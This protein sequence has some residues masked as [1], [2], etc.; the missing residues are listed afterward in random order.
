LVQNR[1]E[2]S[3]P[4]SLEY[5]AIELVQVIWME[6]A[7]ELLTFSWM[8]LGLQCALF[9]FQREQADRSLLFWKSLPVPD[10]IAVCAK[11]VFVLGVLPACAALSMVLVHPLSLSLASLMWPQASADIWQHLGSRFFD[12][13]LLFPLLYM[14]VSAVWITPWVAWA[15]L[16]SACMP[17][18]PPLLFIAPIGALAVWHN[19]QGTDASFASW[20]MHLFKGGPRLAFPKHSL[21]AWQ[22]VWSQFAGQALLQQPQIW[23]GLLVTVACLWACTVFRRR[24]EAL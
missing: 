6:I 21:D 22:S 16:S 10:W 12:H 9:C 18:H 3:L 15:M 1:L 4:L 5:L 19:L 20:V 2:Q 17:K 7:A 14:A 23:L 8:V 11:G 13:G 24:A